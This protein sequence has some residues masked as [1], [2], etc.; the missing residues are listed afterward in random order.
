MDFLASINEP[1]LSRYIKR[2]NR[3]MNSVMNNIFG[4]VSCLFS[5]LF[6]LKFFFKDLYMFNFYLI[7][8]LT[9]YTHKKQQILY[10]FAQ[11]KKKLYK[12]CKCVQHLPIFMCLQYKFTLY[13]QC[14]FLYIKRIN[15]KSYSNFAIVVF[16]CSIFTVLLAAFFFVCECIKLQQVCYIIFGLS[17]SRYF[18]L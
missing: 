11:K 7:C 15:G 9:L 18:T 10:T 12:F 3:L 8:K 5:P 17:N 16:V 4:L 6:F 14:I 2:A 13:V 1:L